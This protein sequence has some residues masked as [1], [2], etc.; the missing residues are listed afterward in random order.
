MLKTKEWRK[1]H[2]EKLYNFCSSP[3]ILRILNQG[4]RD[5]GKFL[6][7][8]TNGGFSRRAQLDG[9]SYLKKYIMKLWSVLK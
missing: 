2:N 7:N 3:N 6:N 4:L 1:Q 8:C 5:V 9:V